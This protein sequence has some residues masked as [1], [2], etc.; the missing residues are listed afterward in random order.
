ME[1]LEGKM[2]GERKWA[3]RLAGP[4]EARSG[5]TFLKGRAALVGIWVERDSYSVMSF[6]EIFTCHTVHTCEVHNS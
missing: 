6:S 3:T 1:F 4:F 5:K 2:Q